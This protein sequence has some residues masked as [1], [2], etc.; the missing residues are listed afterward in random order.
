MNMQ[1]ETFLFLDVD[2]VLNT[3][4]VTSCTHSVAD[5]EEID[6]NM[7]HCLR[8]L[9]DGIDELAHGNVWLVLS[10]TWRCDE[11][12]HAKLLTKL[13]RGGI[14]RSRFHPTLPATPRLNNAG[15]VI[16]LSM[17]CFVLT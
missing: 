4:S 11:Q 7:V 6:S 5:V 3:N 16:F 1:P 14:P 12:L 13:E 10:S 2:G 8:Q 9:L 17:P 15:N